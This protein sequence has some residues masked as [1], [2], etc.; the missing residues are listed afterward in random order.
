MFGFGI[1]GNVPD[2]R[3]PEKDDP[4]LIRIRQE[5]RMLDV[6]RELASKTFGFMDL[7]SSSDL[8]RQK[9]TL[10]DKKAAVDAEEA[11]GKG[12]KRA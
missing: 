8:A 5:K 7:I 12:K 11:K 4:D 9:K 6:Q 10:A 1:F 2:P 3:R